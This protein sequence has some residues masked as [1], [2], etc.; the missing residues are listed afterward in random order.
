MNIF[1]WV[2]QIVLATVFAGAGLMKL[3][4]PIDVLR[5]KIGGW[6]DGVPTPLIRLVGA[7]EVAAAVGLA[8]PPAVGVLAW[9]APLAAVGLAVIM[10]G[11]AVIHGRRGEWASTG[12]NVLLGLVAAGLAWARFGP[13]PFS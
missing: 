7:L 4:R 8:L 12:Q 10:V 11:A 9:L 6:V 5:A 3:T 2:V 1:L 13:Y